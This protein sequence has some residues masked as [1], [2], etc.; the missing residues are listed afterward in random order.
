MIRRPPRSTP[1][2]SSA[3]SDVYKRQLTGCTTARDWR[4]SS[5][6]ARADAR[7]TAESGTPPSFAASIGPLSDIVTP[8]PTGV[9]T[10]TGADAALKRRKHAQANRQQGQR[11]VERRPH[12]R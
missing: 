1:L 2:Y 3:A 10:D 4:Q 12:Q 9:G 8:T 7:N 11:S 5:A 6:A